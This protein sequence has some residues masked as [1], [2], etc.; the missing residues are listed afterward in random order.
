VDGA[1]T[2]K[3]V[4]FASFGITLFMASASAQ[5]LNLSAVTRIPGCTYFVEITD[6]II[7]KDTSYKQENL[8]GLV[9]VSQNDKRD[10]C[11]NKG[12]VLKFSFGVNGGTGLPPLPVQRGQSI[13]IG[14]QYGLSTGFNRYFPIMNRQ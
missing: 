1:L 12:E 14:S 13:W 8:T 2:V 10:E 4:V 6:V 9:L 5:D 3:T 11:S 7:S